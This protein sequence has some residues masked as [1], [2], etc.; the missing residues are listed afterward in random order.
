M[1]VHINSGSGEL[2]AEDHVFGPQLTESE[3]LNS[4]IGRTAKK[5]S[6]KG[7]RVY[8]DV[9]L[10]A[11]DGK[12]LGATLGFL[13][14]NALERINLKVVPVEAR[15]VPWS[16]ETEN[17]IKHFHDEWVLTELGSGS[18]EF[19]WGTVLS[20]VEPHWNSAMVVIDYSRKHGGK[21]S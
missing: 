2:V 16:K 5:V 1:N 4:S 7:T 11:G 13:P 3:F 15:N 10:S 6:S 14:G 9:W 21:P 19:P 8:Y 18:H 12:E 17:E 20:T